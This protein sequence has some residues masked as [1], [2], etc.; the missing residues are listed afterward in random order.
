MKWFIIL[1]AMPVLALAENSSDYCS[2]P[3]FTT[4]A[5]RNCRRILDQGLVPTDA[6]K[7]ALQ[8]LKN[9][10]DSFMTDKCFDT[11]RSFD[12]VFN[13]YS[14]PGLAD[15]GDLISKL[16][17]GIPN[18]CSFVINDYDDRVT[19]H[20]GQ[21]KC[22]TRMYYIDLCG[23]SPQ[24]T[25]TLSYVGYGTC[26][27]GRGFR[28]STGQ[29]TSLLGAHV[30]G[31]K[32]FDFQKRDASY[33]RIARDL[34]SYEP[35]DLEQRNNPSGFVP[36][37]PLFGLQRT[38]N[39]AAPDYKYLHVGAYTSAG[40][41]SIPPSQARIIIEMANRGPSLLLNYKRGQMEA[42]DICE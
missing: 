5:N 9:N 2:V 6:F 21:Y 31:G 13:H 10:S 20:N 1:L 22:Q 32:L 4:R 17:Q 27:R 18:K 33:T 41:P 19:T 36:A 34:A 30:T 25:R 12:N 35:R 24:I 38:N 11:Y 3:G 15:S 23:S 39:G 26:K 40:C 29:G 7:Y 42:L 16:D 8:V 28:N 14:T 37:I